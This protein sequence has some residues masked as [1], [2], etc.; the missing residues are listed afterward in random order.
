[1]S[2]VARLAMWSGPRNISTALLRS[3]GNRPDSLVVDEPLYAHYLAVTG[4]DHP[5]RDEIVA[6]GETDWRVVID[7]LLGPVPGD[8]RVYYQKHMAHHLTADIDTDWV[9]RLTNV[10]L[11]RSPR[12]VVA[13]YLRSRSEVTPDDIGLPQQGR[14][15]DE[16]SRHG[17]PPLVIDAGDFLAAPR[18]YLRVLCDLVGVSFTESMLTWPAGPRATDGV[19]GRYW[20]DAVWASTGFT[21]PT[22]RDVNLP[23]SAAA[24]VEAC[25][26][27]Y[28]RLRALRLVVG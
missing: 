16:L 28:E 9:A 19:W 11:L 4:I 14:L 6:A 3:W 25:E 8:V 26:P 22:T 15:Y 21:R 7:G 5:G 10:V 23:R 13:S 12:E 24:V 1:M 27:V 18:E 20:Y 17:S 2:E